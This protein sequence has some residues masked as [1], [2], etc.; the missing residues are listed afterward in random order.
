MTGTRDKG[1]IETLPS[2]SFRLHVYVG[3]DP[4][5]GRPIR[6][7][8][9]HKTLPEAESALR[10]IR[11]RLDAGAN[12]DRS[13]TVRVLLESWMEV[14]DHELSTS[15]TDEGYIRRTIEPYLGDWLV[16]KLQH[17][18][19]VVDRLYVNLRKC[20]K[21]C[22]GKLDVDHRT[23]RP[24]ECRVVKHHR[25]K[26]HDCAQ[27]GCRVIECR[28]HVCRPMAPTTIRRRIN[29][30]LSAAYGYA[31][32]WGWADR[33]PASLVHLPKQ[34]GRKRARPQDASKVAELLNLAF[35]EMPDFGLFL[36]LAATTGARRGELAAL[37]WRDADLVRGL[38]LLD[39]N[40]VVRKGQKQIKA[41]KTDEPRPLSLD[42]ISVT[43][44]SEVKTAQETMLGAAGL[45][46]SPD[47][48]V[49][50][51]EPDGSIPWNPDTFT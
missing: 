38:L 28:P 15:E 48:Y 16:S 9:T 19:D 18:V 41:T 33:N 25:R 3:K 6:I 34:K 36:W 20:S 30:I 46:L 47:A 1:H 27:A 12:P 39:E 13:A 11:E 45:T 5:T 40:Y 29:A 43:L 8:E 31:M 10:K 49:F 26:A 7:R 50:S 14:A 37:R 24:H 51:P 21:L 17:R 32:T 42:T 2:G 22:A 4:I 35:A 44:L 23:N